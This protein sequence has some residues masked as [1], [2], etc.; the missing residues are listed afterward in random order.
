ML[1]FAA[2]TTLL[3]EPTTLADFLRSYQLCCYSRIS[4]HFMEPED[5]LMC[6]QPDITESDV[7]M[8]LGI[9]IKMGGDICE[10]HE[11]VTT[12]ELLSSSFHL[13]MAK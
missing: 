13:L 6:L 8:F 12:G 3:P 7:F 11:R 4:Q 2:P 5:S 9:I 1:Y 10:E